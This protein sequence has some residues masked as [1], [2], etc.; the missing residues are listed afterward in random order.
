MVRAANFEFE[1]LDEM[2]DAGSIQRRI[3]DRHFLCRRDG[4]GQV[5]PRSPS[6]ASAIA[7]TSITGIQRLDI[8]SNAERVT[9]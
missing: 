1:S 5:P 2:I 4:D 9:H 6:A 7:R 8:S 3:L